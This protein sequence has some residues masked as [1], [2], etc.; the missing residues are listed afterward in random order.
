MSGTL[1]SQFVRVRRISKFDPMKHEFP[2]RHSVTEVDR[3]RYTSA[4][5]DGAAS[6]VRNVNRLPQHDELKKFAADLLAARA[7]R[8][9]VLPATLF[10]E[11]GFDMLLALYC[12]LEG[13]RLTVSNMYHIS[14]VPDTTA[15]RWIDRIC[16]LGLAR[17]RPNPLDARVF[18]VEIEPAGRTGIEDYL[19]QAW[20]ILY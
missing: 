18:F 6:V 13:R 19:L 2:G 11:P 20:N 5:P 16:E 15:L 9:S 12:N 8:K 14:Q 4:S 1:A 3:A 10:G 17:R 7:A